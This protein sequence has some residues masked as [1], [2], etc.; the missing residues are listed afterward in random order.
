MSGDVNE[1]VAST[2]NFY[3]RPIDSDGS[4]TYLGRGVSHVDIYPIGLL[5]DLRQMRVEW[6]V[7]TRRGALRGFVR[8]F[9]RSWWRR[10]Y[11][12][13]YHAETD[14]PCAT[15]CGHGWT[16]ARAR[17]DLARHVAEVSRERYG[18]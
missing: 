14:S 1:W 11:W 15:R 9:A 12:S 8:R 7:H 18:R 3:W 6:W 17:L 5:G 16:R 2:G 13:G 4:W 10:S